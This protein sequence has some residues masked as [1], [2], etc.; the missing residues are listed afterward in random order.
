MPGFRPLALRF[1]CCLLASGSLGWAQA[2]PEVDPNEAIRRGDF[3][4]HVD[5]IAGD[6][7]IG[8]VFADQKDDAN[9][10]FVTVYSIGGCAP[11]AT[12]LEDW[13]TSKSLRAFANPSDPNKSWAHFNVYKKDDPT[14]AFRFERFRVRG[15]PTI[16]VQPPNTGRHGDPS[17]VVFLQTG[18]DA[19]D[20]A[21]D[22]A[23]AKSMSEAIRRYLQKREQERRVADGT[24]AGPA[25]N[26]P[27]DKPAGDSKNAEAPVPLVAPVPSV[28]LSPPESSAEV[29]RGPDRSPPWDCDG[30]SCRP[31]QP[32]NHD[33]PPQDVPPPEK[34]EPA[35][36]STFQIVTTVVGGLLG[37][38]C[39]AC[40][41]AI[42]LIPVVLAFRWAATPKEKIVY[43]AG[44]PAAPSPGKATE[45]PAAAS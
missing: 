20:P 33:Q 41:A 25:P 23:L 40:F 29:G 30:E 7:G 3:V 10:W 19:N 26:K 36:W 37:L 15:F 17:T 14:Q 38:L 45:P 42:C 28:V 18:Y 1:L 43:V 6:D 21:R 5:G 35:G 8:D 27:D 2:L 12:L 16:L 31:K 9:K 11:C 32:F 39:L 13:K 4:Q 34:K 22:V 44:P 24:G